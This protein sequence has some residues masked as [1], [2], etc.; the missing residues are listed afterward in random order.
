MGE[1]T[2]HKVG[3]PSSHWCLAHM[4]SILGVC[5]CGGGLY[6]AQHRQ[7]TGKN[8]VH[9]ASEASGTKLW[10]L[11][12][13]PVGSQPHF[14]ATLQHLLAFPK[15]GL[16]LNASDAGVQPSWRSTGQSAWGRPKKTPLFN[17]AVTRFMLL[18]ERQ[19]SKT[20]SVIQ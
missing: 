15:Y 4:Q 19:N 18:S 16:C 13:G 9:K 6:N 12:V 7:H 5:V 11:G 3:K 17:S 1:R 20:G 10:T 8:Q 2:T 14:P